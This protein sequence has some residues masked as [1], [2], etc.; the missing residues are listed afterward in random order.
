MDQATKSAKVPSP[1][2]KSFRYLPL[3]AAFATICLFPA[4]AQNFSGNVLTSGSFDDVEP[5]Y[6]PWAGVDDKGSI[7]GIDGKQIAVD[8][9]GKLQV[10]GRTQHGTAT[11][12]PGIACADMNGDGKNDLVLADPWGYFWFFA[13][14]GTPAKANFTQGEVM[15]IWLAEE[16]VARDTEGVDCVVPRIQ[17]LDIDGAKKL[18][19]IAGTYVGRLFRIPNSGSSSA[20][21]FKPTLSRD[22]LQINTHKKGV[23][24]CN[25]LSPFMTPLF[26]NQNKLDLIMGEGTYSAN[27]IYKLSSL[28]SNGTPAYD[29]DHFN[30]I[31]PGMGLEQI[32]PVVIDW[33]NDGK[34]D[35]IC[36]DRTGHINLYLNNSTD[37]DKP[38]FAP[39]VN[40]KIGGKDTFGKC[41]T[42]AVGDLSDNKLPNL[43]IGSDDGT[44]SYAVNTGK[45]G[46]PA[47]LIPPAPLK[48]VLP[49]DYHYTSLKDWDKY[50]AFG[51]PYELV[52]ATNPQIEP[53]FKFPEG[54]KVKNA[55][56]FWVVPFKSTYFP[57]RYYP[58]Q[59]GEYSEHVI[60][61]SKDFDL[62][63]NKRYRVHMWVKA[64]RNVDLR[65]RLWRNYDDNPKYQPP[66]QVTKPVSVGTSWTESNTDIRYDNSTDPATKDWSFAFEFR[67]TGQATL[68]IADVQIQEAL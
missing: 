25:Y 28:N 1:L 5:D 4:R 2:L 67:F 53:G 38:T 3:A 6:N 42:V 54:L 31:I 68:Y 13:N 50:Q 45:L 30:K 15:P 7:H 51:V 17:L 58:Q 12:A 49:P 44:V 61:C 40:V 59:E 16:K 66:E 24:W 56:K 23:L 27:S 19:I 33:N 36:G 39:P 47:F 55:L 57:E 65:F 34:P 46:E 63:L 8:D 60:R 32:T 11:F 37:A 18:D 29:E 41:V 64:D 21:S 52:G 10:N 62:K 43:L 35:V 9:A 26:N 22:L 48:G 20:P 14:T